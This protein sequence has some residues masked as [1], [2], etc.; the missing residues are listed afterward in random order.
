MALFFIAISFIN[1][2]SVKKTRDNTI[3]LKSLIRITKANAEI[4]DE[5]KDYTGCIPV[6]YESSCNGYSHA[7]KP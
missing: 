2:N 3:L 6:Q 1:F 5:F 7:K 4:K